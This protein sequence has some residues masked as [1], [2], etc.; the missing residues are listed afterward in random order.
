[1]VTKHKIN[2][3]MLSFKTT[4]LFVAVSQIPIPDPRTGKRWQNEMYPAD[5]AIKLLHDLCEATEP[6]RFQGYNQ[7]IPKGK[8]PRGHYHIG[9]IS[10]TEDLTAAIKASG[11]KTGQ[12]I[13]DIPATDDRLTA[14]QEKLEEVDYP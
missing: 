2:C 6:K 5:E 10:P 11:L 13:T 4:S 3:I 14:E 12:F 1:M 9:K 8:V 7:W